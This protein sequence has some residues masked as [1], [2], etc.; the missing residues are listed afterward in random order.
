[1]KIIDPTYLR[2]IH[3]G[4]VTGSVNKD[5]ASSLPYGLVGVYEEAFQLSLNVDERQNFLECFAV[6]ALL[7]KEVSVSFMKFLFNG[8]N[9]QKNLSYIANY[10]KWF[11]IT[12]SVKYQLY[13]DR[14]RIFL[15][16][17]ISDNLRIKVNYNLIKFLSQNE[18]SKEFNDY[19]KEW[20]GFHYIMARKISLG[21]EF[22]IQNAFLQ[23]ES[24]WERTFDL[25][26]NEAFINSKYIISK[27]E[28]DFFAKLKSRHH[29]TNAAKL[30]VKD[31][32]KIDWDQLQHISHETRFHFVLGEILA[33]Q[34]D[35]LPSKTINQ[36]IFNEDHYLSYVLAY[37]WK[38]VCWKKEEIPNAELI[39]QIKSNGSPYLRILLRQIDGGRLLLNK[40]PI[41]DKLDYNDCWEY[42]SEDFIDFI[43]NG[44]SL[45]KSYSDN[46]GL[47]SNLKDNNL[48]FIL[49]DF[50]SLH[51]KIEVLQNSK[52]L[53][54]KSPFFNQLVEILWI[55]PAWEI[56]EIGN[57]L[58]RQKLIS[59]KEI[60]KIYG[61]LDWV[62]SLAK[63][64]K[65]YSI[66]ILI[67]DIIE[68]T[69]PHIEYFENLLDI[70]LNY[71]DSQIR[72]QLIASANDYFSNNIDSRCFVIFEKKIASL[73]KLASDIWETQ[74]IISL[75]KTLKSHISDTQLEY[76]CKEHNLISKIPNALNLDYNTFWKTAEVLRL[77]GEL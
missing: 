44:S 55:H 25:Y 65:T 5:N 67:F 72:G 47:V 41:L 49:K 18:E 7:M 26:C 1:M 32:E 39:D 53:I 57:D 69:G 63:C 54:L 75:F 46:S 31:F 70:I 24:W 68:T 61:Y 28:I 30:I 62:L 77:K 33:I 9:Y 37:T 58:V 64:R 76:Y 51:I 73:C 15:L 20:M 2:T 59:T 19:S 21:F 38:Y 43:N 11:N 8:D 12:E 35:H 17:K 3:D 16:Q 74:E 10:S 66:S 36:I 6:W 40:T 22:L 42:V 4:L 52:K 27:Y 71:N 23:K 60:D 34:F 14:L 50:S 29:C 56:G 48:Y 13:H 45:L